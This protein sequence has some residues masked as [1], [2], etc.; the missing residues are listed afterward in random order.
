MLATSVDK[1]VL[2]MSHKFHSLRDSHN[3]AELSSIFLPKLGHY[4]F[5]E[6][7]LDA[8]ALW[9][10]AA[11][12]RGAAIARAIGDPQGGADFGDEGGWREGEVSAESVGKDGIFGYWVTARVC[13]PPGVGASPNHDSKLKFR[14]I[15][16]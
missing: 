8:A 6:S 4:R 1:S 12:D 2:I 5:A 7:Q 14:L 16:E 3:S 11:E 10:H 9:Q 13:G 15:G